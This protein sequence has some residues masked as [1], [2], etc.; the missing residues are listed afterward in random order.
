MS[1]EVVFITGAS[2][3]IGAALA[4]EYAARGFDVFL[5]ARRKDRLE[6]LCAALSSPNSQ[7]DYFVADVIDPLAMSAAVDHAL[8]RFKRIDVVYANAGFGVVGRFSDLS[9][10]DYRRQFETN[11]FG[12]LNTVAASREALEKS[13]GRLAIVGSVVA[14]IALP[15]G[16]PYAMSK[17]AI[18]AF[19]SSLYHEW[20]KTGVSVTL[21]NPG[22]VQSEI[23]QVSNKGEYRAHA[24][25]PIPQ[26]LAMSSEK[27]ARDIKRAVARRKREVVITAHGKLLVFIER[28]F[29][30]LFN[31]ILTRVGVSARNEPKIAEV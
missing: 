21:I 27:A 4:Q 12:V 2:S 20:R 29:P 7:C 15:N 24:R 13:H 18:R 14:Y 30:G 9:I 28:H 11:V 17:F 25:D 16:S 31:F 1:R 10:E 6:A 19:A 8:K 5:V 26:W 22:F 3:G 23:R